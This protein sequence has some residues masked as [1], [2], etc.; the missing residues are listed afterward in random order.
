[1]KFSPT[2]INRL[3]VPKGKSE[4]LLFDVTTPG[5]GIRVRAGGHRSFI[6][7]YRF[8]GESRRDRLQRLVGPVTDI[9]ISQCRERA[10]QVLKDA[11][12]GRD[13]QCTDS[14]CRDNFRRAGPAPRRGNRV[15]RT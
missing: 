11:S 14:F 13:P 8:A 1:M 12:A 3:Q 6:V 7:Q 15:L 5:F 2:S 4:I 10:E 9:E